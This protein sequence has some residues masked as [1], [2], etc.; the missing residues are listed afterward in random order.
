MTLL[1]SHPKAACVSAGR[2]RQST[3]PLTPRRPQIL[4]YVAAGYSARI[5][6]RLDLSAATVGMHLENIVERRQVSSRAAAVARL[7]PL[8]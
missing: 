3:L 5:A 1:R 8:Q 7:T 4:R 6:R 2:S